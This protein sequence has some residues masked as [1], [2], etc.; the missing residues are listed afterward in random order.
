MIDSLTIYKY[1][2]YSLDDQIITIKP[3]DNKPKTFL[4]NNIN[5]SSFNIKIVFANDAK[6]NYSPYPTDNTDY[7]GANYYVP[8]LYKSF[9]MQSNNN[10][11]KITTPLS[12]F[13]NASS[14]VAVIVILSIIVFIFLIVLVVFIKKNK[15]KKVFDGT[16]R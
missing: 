7:Y 5:D 12:V 13:K 4:P 6:Q 15:I 11:T 9:T 2:S 3:L 8:D 16:D 14:S 10:S 1:G